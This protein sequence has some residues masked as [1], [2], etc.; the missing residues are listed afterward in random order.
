MVTVVVILGI[1][2]AVAIGKFQDL[3][4]EGHTAAAR[5]TLNELT[6]AGMTTVYNYKIERD[7]DPTT[8]EVSPGVTL[9]VNAQGW[10]GSLFDNAAC[11][12]LWQTILISSE[13]MNPWMTVPI[14]T[15]AEG[16]EYIGT[17]TACVYLYKPDTTPLQAILYIPDTGVPGTG[18][19]QGFNI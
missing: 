6:S 5:G 4:E 16:W 7:A 2:G 8:V 13:P 11:L 19:F 15:T 18:Y 10:P 9:P 3:S 1:V 14:L 12:T 17:G